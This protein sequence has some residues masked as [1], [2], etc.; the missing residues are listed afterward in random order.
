MIAWCDLALAV[1]GTVTLDITAHRKPMVG[2]YRTGLATWLLARLLIRL[3][4]RLLP[5][6]IAEREIVPEFVPYLGG[7]ARIVRQVSRILLD[8]KHG[9]VQAEEL[10]RVC[11]RFANHDPA[12]EAARAIVELVRE[13]ARGS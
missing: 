3:P 2:V 12:A 9:A 5:N 8:S 11:L 6:I 7:P 10:H 1:S 13:D 4:H